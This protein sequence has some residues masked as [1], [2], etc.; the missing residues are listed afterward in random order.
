[1]S[2]LIK[3]VDWI[4]AKC[5]NHPIEVFLAAVGMIGLVVLFVAA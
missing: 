3:A 2:R 4:E 5:R 1:M